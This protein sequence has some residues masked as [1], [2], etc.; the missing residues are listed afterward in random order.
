[1]SQAASD[2]DLHVTDGVAR[3]EAEAIGLTATDEEFAAGGRAPLGRVISD[4]ASP[5]FFSVR[6]RMDPGRFSAPGRFVA[7]EARS[8]DGREVL[9][10][11]RVEDVH[12]FN[13]HED[14]ASSTLREALPFGTSY[15]TEGAST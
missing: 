7:I 12:E 5:S 13:P 14:A 2:N 4:D 9:L 6:F 3:A 8:D 11:A 10:L 1:M 15:A